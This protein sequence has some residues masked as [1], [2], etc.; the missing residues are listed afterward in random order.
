MDP[1]ASF[2][3]RAVVSST[4]IPLSESFKSGYNSMEV[5]AHGFG[6]ND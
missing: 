1:R 4:F 3:F 6:A 2:G 5:K